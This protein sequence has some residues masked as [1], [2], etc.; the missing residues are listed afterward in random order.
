M[1]ED[2]DGES[3]EIEEPCRLSNPCIYSCVL[4]R[5]SPRP[6][7]GRWKHR[8][9]KGVIVI[10][11]INCGASHNFIATELVDKLRL[12]I[13]DTPYLAEVGAGHKVRCK[14][15]CAQLQFQIHQLQETRDF[16]LFTLR[17][18]DMVLGLDWLVGLGEII[19]DFRKLELTVRQWERMIR[20]TGNPALA[21]MGML[22]PSSYNIKVEHRR[23]I[24]RDKRT[25]I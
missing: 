21:K 23:C 7:L 10:I 16:Y 13:Q 20:I 11:L 8:L 24:I 4:C 18:I 17:G 15:K 1:E 5:D 12:T 2:E 3:E 14:G 25:S 9:V 22:H 6:D 19:A